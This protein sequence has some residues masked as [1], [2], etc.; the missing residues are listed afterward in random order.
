MLMSW[1][2]TSFKGH[3]KEKRGY[4]LKEKLANIVIKG[5]V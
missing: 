4:F 1:S 3:Q 5:E 2:K